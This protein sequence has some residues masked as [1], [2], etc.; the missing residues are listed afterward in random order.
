MIA[1]QRF[2]VTM[3]STRNFNFLDLE[4]CTSDFQLNSPLLQDNSEKELKK[5][6]SEL[7][8]IPENSYDLISAQSSGYL[9]ESRSSAQQS[10]N[11]TLDLKWKR[12]S[13]SKSTTVSISKLINYVPLLHTRIMLP[14]TPK[15]SE[16][17]ADVDFLAMFK[18]LPQEVECAASPVTKGSSRMRLTPRLNISGPLSPAMLSTM[19]SPPSLLF[20][21][22]ANPQTLQSTLD[23][24][25][26]ERQNSCFDRWAI[27]GSGNLLRFSLDLSSKRN[28]LCKLAQHPGD[29]ELTT[30]NH[31][32]KINLD[33]SHA[34]SL[35]R[36]SSN[37]TNRHHIKISESPVR[38]NRRVEVLTVKSTRVKRPEFLSHSEHDEV[39]VLGKEFVTCQPCIPR[40]SGTKDAVLKDD[41]KPKRQFGFDRSS[42]DSVLGLFKYCQ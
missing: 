28:S 12:I 30:V 8:K 10:P 22:S 36:K 21:K 3:D 40:E 39:L 23:H 15:K 5:Q 19:R 42:R 14:K 34:S 24:P 35:H 2:S 27:P 26:P 33:Y 7:S 16:I 11:Q 38:K 20:T 18:T 31:P 17:P 29:K 13:S 25:R 6:V 1:M 4:S 41:K 9:D 32:D 37:S